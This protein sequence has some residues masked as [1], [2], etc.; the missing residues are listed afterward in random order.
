MD[1]YSDAYIPG[2]WGDFSVQTRFQLP[3]GAWACGV[4]G[5]LN[6]LTGER[7]VANVYPETS[8]YKPTPSI[9]LI[10]FHSWGTW[11]DT[12]TAMAQASLASVGTMY[13]TLKMVCYGN[14]IDVYYD[15][16]R[17]IHAIDDMVDGLP[18]YRSGA[19][20]AHMY[21]YSPYQATFDDFNASLIAGINYPPVLP[22]QI[23]RTMGPL[24]TLLVT[25]TATDPDV[26]ANTL[27]YTLINPPTGAA[28]D[29]NGVISWTPT[30]GQDLT[31]NILT[32]VVTDYNPSATNSQHLSAT[33]SFMVVVN[34]RPVIA[35]DS[36]ALVSEGCSPAN[37]AIDSGE[38]VTVLFALKNAGLN[39]TT[40]LVATLLGTGGVASPSG[41]QTYGVIPTDGSTITQAFSF[42]ANLTC[43][44]TLNATFQ[45]Q[46][47]ATSL[48]NLVVP[49]VLGQTGTVFVQNFDT[50]TAPALP[51]GWTSSSSGAESNWITQAATNQSAPDVAFSPDPANIGLNQLVS[52][53]IQLPNGPCQLSFS[54]MIDLETNTAVEAFDG[55]V[56]EIKIGGGSFTDLLAAGGTFVTNGYSYTIS[57]SWGNPLGGRQAW[58]GTSPGFFPTIV[59]LPAASG[60]TIQLQWRCGTDNSN[61]RSGWRLDSIGITGRICC[62]GTSTNTAP[63]LTVPANQIINELT[64]LNVSAS[65]TDTDVP[66][67]TLTFS[68]ISAPAGM[69]I[70]TNTGAIS[71]TPTEAQGPSTNTVTVKVTDNGSPPLSDTK[72][73]TVTVN[74]VNN[75]PVLTVP[76]NQVINELTTL[77]V[78]ASATDSDL[79]P[80]T[81]TF[82]LVTAPVGMTINTNSGAV[83]WTPTEAQGPSTNTV[84]V[85]V[86]DNGSP[87]LSDAKSFIVTVNEVNS[88]PVLTVPAGQT[89]N[90]LAPLNVSASAT[91]SDIPANILTFSLMLAPAGMTINTNT[92]A[93]SWT[94]TEAQGPSTN[95]VTVRERTM[96]S[97]ASATPSRLP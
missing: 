91:D 19:F 72:S 78:S 9:R 66:P 42:S 15:G 40:N 31:T 2:V 56:L 37:G 4:S 34:S 8:P 77:N 30:S 75:A 20:G 53:V 57:T 73:F 11:S 63:V 58:S 69:T 47:G 12:F 79:P 87:P 32:T 21:T 28:I 13:H 61:G 49:F 92:G 16:T 60:Q 38:H 7:Y 5:R 43:G 44:S 22:A 24:T 59:N 41:A 95:T 80:N 27:T 82:S 83:S 55:A 33:N 76:A 90:E 3:S 93:I 46:D 48:G 18:F 68:L 54:Q 1:Y 96:A 70:N 25:N 71:W 51:A 36:T 86:T 64:T 81:V 62:T 26:P 14:T 84:T 39:S 85:R 74:E 10:K 89:I 88:T 97:Q 65:A 52:P 23:D 17:V 50:V 45:L 94:P 67:D 35:V 29:T 6:P